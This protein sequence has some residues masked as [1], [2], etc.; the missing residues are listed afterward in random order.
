MIRLFD[1]HTKRRTYD[2]D[3]VWRLKLDPER[4]GE[5]DKWFENFP[6][7][8]METVIPSCWNNELGIY[9]YEGL[10]WYKTTFKTGKRNVNFQFHGVTGLSEVY[11]DGK[12]LGSHYGGFTGFNFLVKDLNPG[13]HTLVVAV[14]NTHDDLNTI[15]LAKVDWFH[16]GGITRSVE[17]MELED[18]WVK[19]YRI[20]YALDKGLK[21]VTLN[22]SAVVEVLVPGNFNSKFNIYM[23]DSIVHSEIVAG[24]GEVTLKAENIV[25]EEISLWDTERPTLYKVRFEIDNDDIIDRIGFREIKV[26][27]KKVLLNGRELYL[28]GVNRHEDHPDWGFAVPFKLMKRDMDII[29]NLGCNT[30]RGSHYPNAPI[31]LDY[32]DEQG[33]LFWEE[34]PM[35]GYP[36]A[37]LKNPLILERGLKMHEEMV[38]RDLHHPCIIFWGMHN[39]IDT[40]TQAAYELTKAFA[41]KVRSL[42]STRPLT[43]A[44]MFALDDIC[45]PLVDIVSVN[46]YHG[47]YDGGLEAWPVFLQKLKE[48]L[49]REGLSHMPVIMSEFGAGAIYGDSTFEGPKWTENYQEKYLDYTLRLFYNDPHICGTYIWQYCD[50]RTAKEMEMGRPRSFNNKGIV[51]E[52]RKPKLA[53]WT[54]QKIYKEIK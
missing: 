17:I 47:W 44:T 22:F 23:N 3:G 54:V 26:E 42:D 25:L 5:T 16:Y 2:L 41:E 49:S 4:R 36:E 19:D 48:K 10:A 27:N 46:R 15:P 37:P 32:L 52:Y 34:I 50:I 39:E 14:D 40:R 43:Y 8:S 35:W 31:F 1:R 13:E 30:I 45:Y 18:A 33:I 21:N 53:Y 11:V 7:D 6:Q 24:E 38:L 29:K 20:D 51:N 9:D 12:L 28:K